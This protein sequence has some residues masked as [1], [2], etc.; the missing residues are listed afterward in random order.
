ME[1]SNLPFF[2]TVHYHKSGISR[3]ELEDGQPTVKSLVRLHGCAGWLGSI[4]VA[5]ANHF[6]FQQG[7]EKVKEDKDIQ[8]MLS[9]S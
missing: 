7:K 2:W 8:T 1:K 6:W 5:K 3:R 9:L 4:L